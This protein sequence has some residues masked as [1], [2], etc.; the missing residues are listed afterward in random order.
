MIEALIYEFIATWLLG[1]MAYAVGAAISYRSIKLPSIA[2]I[3]FIYLQ[4]WVITFVARFA[5]GYLGYTLKWD[6]AVQGGVA[7]FLLPIAAGAYFARQLLLLQTRRTVSSARQTP[8]ADLTETSWWR[9]RSAGFRLW[10][11][12]SVLWALGVLFF[13]I[14]FDPYNNG[15]WSYMDEDEYFHMLF[16]MFGPPLFLGASIYAYAKWVK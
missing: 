3:G 14:A 11:F 10:S 6:E 9:R 8:K 2:R 7:K 12:G 13:V 15:D 5:F 16:V 4:V 1:L